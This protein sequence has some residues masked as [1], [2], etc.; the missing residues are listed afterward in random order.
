MSA[1]LSLGPQ[2]DMVGRLGWLPFVE[3]LSFTLQMVFATVCGKSAATIECR[4][5]GAPRDCVPRARARAGGKRD[6][7]RSDIEAQGKEFPLVF[8]LACR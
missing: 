2:F 5:A 1:I 3:V 6:P 4:T 8:L 7:R